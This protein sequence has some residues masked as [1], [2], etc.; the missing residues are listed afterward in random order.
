MRTLQKKIREHQK[1]LNLILEQSKEI[2]SKIK[3]LFKKIKF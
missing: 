1:V 3:L 2:V